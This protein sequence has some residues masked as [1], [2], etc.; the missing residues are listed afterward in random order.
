METQTAGEAHVTTNR[1]V[2]LTVLILPVLLISMDG[3]ILGFAIP[4]LSASLD[5]S[6]SQLL[7]IIDIYAF[8]L[9]GLL[10]T[11]GVLGDRI[12]RRKLLMLG[13]A[14]F[15]LA[16]IFAAFATS[17]EMLIAARAL[18]GVAGATLMPSTLSL[19]R[20]IFTDDRERQFAIAVWAT[21]FAVGS[22][23]GP[24]VGGFLLEHY[25]WGSIFLMAAPT[26]ALL[27]VLAPLILPESKDPSPGPFD[28][29][30][31]GLSMTAML[32]TVYAIKITAERG[33]SMTVLVALIIGVVSA[34]M[35]IRRQRSTEDP[36]IDISLFSVPRFRS[37][38]I[39]NMIACFGF[40]GSMYFLT[41]YMQLVLDMT[42]MR[43]GIQLMPAV[44]ASIVTMLLSPVASARVGAFTVISIGLAAG[45][46]GF[47]LMVIA[48]D[49]GS[50]SLATTAIVLIGAG[51]GAALTVSIDGIIAA[52][53]PERAGAG[54][55]V[56]ETAN[57]LGTAMGTA[58]LGSIAAAVYRS[59][60]SAATTVP[61]DYL[62]RAKETLGEA[63]VLSV[64]L[65]GPE[66]EALMAAAKEAFIGGLRLASA[67]AV[68]ALALATASAVRYRSAN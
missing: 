40:A 28:L 2:A 14:G 15:S 9:A 45:A 31:A 8:V 63:T 11:M 13:A 64:E 24:V 19:I 35:F 23:V 67:V 56:S 42:P 55:S 39:G 21:T 54:A 37:A 33:F 61:P 1:W 46:L 48:P 65:G 50:V 34:T 41:Q 12:G 16:S 43:A 30:S 25:W 60:L 27:L 6:S 36:M 66:G 22:A 44:I 38:V 68:V 17:A 58:V 29:M 49:S 51:L 10:V 47:G 7:W 62:V 20:N 5:P 4:K 59:R 52:V 32:P 57:E 53:P 18:L 26:T 3:T